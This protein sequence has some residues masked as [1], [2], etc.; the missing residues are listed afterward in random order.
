[1]RNFLAQS[2]ARTQEDQRPGME[3]Y[4]QSRM[5]E[6]RLIHQQTASSQ[7]T[8]VSLARLWGK[9]G[10]DMGHIQVRPRGHG[11]AMVKDKDSPS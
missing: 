7:I 3:G 1:M 6:G 9:P 8:G 5:A 2:Q 10:R 11:G 4:S